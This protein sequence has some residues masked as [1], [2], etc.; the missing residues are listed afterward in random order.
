MLR[1][2][3]TQRHLHG[4]LFRIEHVLSR[5]SLNSS[6]ASSRDRKHAFEQDFRGGGLARERERGIFIFIK[7]SI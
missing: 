6:H 4:A 3:W 1:E 5:E 2:I 7:F